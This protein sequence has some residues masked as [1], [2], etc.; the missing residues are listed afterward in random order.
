M[1]RNTRAHYSLPI[2]FF[3]H[4]WLLFPDG[5]CWITPTHA[6]CI[7]KMFFE[8]HQSKCSPNLIHDN[9]TYELH[10]L[11]FSLL[12][13]GIPILSYIVT[14]ILFVITLIAELQKRRSKIHYRGKRKYIESARKQKSLFILKQSGVLG[15]CLICSFGLVTI[16]RLT[17]CSFMLI[18]PSILLNTFFG[19]VAVIIYLYFKLPRNEIVESQR[20]TFSLRNSVLNKNVLPSLTHGY[21]PTVTQRPIDDGKFGGIY[22]GDD[23]DDSDDSDEYEFDVFEIS[24][25]INKTTT[26]T[27]DD[28]TRSVDTSNH[29]LRLTSVCSVTTGQVSSSRS[30]PDDNVVV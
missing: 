29:L 27:N 22:L 13:H 2:I 21:S 4:F 5:R 8:Q 11:S 28:A 14:I 16:S 26:T 24:D 20:T 25:N 30:K 1:N 10:T 3:F 12:E 6:K 7:N 19:S 9:V 23:D 17:C 15:L 18:L